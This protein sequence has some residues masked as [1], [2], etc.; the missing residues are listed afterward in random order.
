MNNVVD[1]LG[2]IDI[3]LIVNDKF[4]PLFLK[5]LDSSNRDVVVEC[6]YAV[7]FSLLSSLSH[8]HRVHENV[9]PLASHFLVHVDSGQR[10]GTQSQSFSVEAIADLFTH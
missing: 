4:L 3:N 7:R 5:F 2:W 9:E 8:T 6:F 10:N 1:G